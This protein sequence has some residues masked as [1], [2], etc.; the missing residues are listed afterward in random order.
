MHM[1]KPL[2]EHHWEYQLLALEVPGMFGS[3]TSMVLGAGLTLVGH[4]RVVLEEAREKPGVG[5]ALK[6]FGIKWR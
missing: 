1:M 2:N 4:S 5:Q 6:I 3:L